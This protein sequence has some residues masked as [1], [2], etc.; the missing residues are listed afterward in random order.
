MAHWLLSDGTP[1]Y[2]EDTGAGP[3]IVFV[4]GWTFTTR[5][6]ER[7]TTAL[8]SQFRVVSCDLRGAGRSGKTPAGHGFA[9][10]AQDLR[11]LVVG[12][13]LRDVTLVGWAMGATV[14]VHYMA[15]EHAME[16]VIGL[17]WVDHSP[18]FY[19]VSDWPFALYGSLTPEALE[20]TLDQLLADRP[21]ATNA[22]LDD[23]FSEGISEKDREAFYA[24]SFLTPTS[25]A[26]RMLGA[27]A[28]TDL[29]PRLGT[30]TVPCL[31][32]NGAASVVPFEVGR[33]MA[34]RVE[35]GQ[36]VVLAEAGHAPFWDQPAEFNARVTEFVGAAEQSGDKSR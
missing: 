35:S 26:V 31:F 34:R 16:R 10:Y 27:V 14:A 17:V 6:W 32:I 1:L 22:L 20:Q 9:R 3:V 29:R 25:V 11:E 23:I 12:L 28:A 36:E 13:D 24:D 18:C 2:Y 33:W 30:L 4:P 7:Q 21:A 15:L 8:S 19:S 5:V